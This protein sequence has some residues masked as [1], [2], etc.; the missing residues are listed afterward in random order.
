MPRTPRLNASGSVLPQGARVPAG[1]VYGGNPAV[2]VRKLSKEQIEENEVAAE[3]ISDLAAKHMDEF[4]PYDT[5][6]Q[7]REIMTKGK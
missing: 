6:Y 3:A 1:E 4:L 7:L 5:N 2:F